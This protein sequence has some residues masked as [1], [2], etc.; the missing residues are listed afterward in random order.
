MP[1]RLVNATTKT[2]PPPRR[3]P[4]VRLKTVHCNQ[5][6][7]ASTSPNATSGWPSKV[8]S[9]R[10]GSCIPT[11]AGPNAK[12]PGRYY[13]KCPVGSPSRQWNGWCDNNIQDVSHSADDRTRHTKYNVDLNNNLRE[14]TSAIRNTV[15]ILVIH[16]LIGIEICVFLV[17]H[18][19]CRY[20]ATLSTNHATIKLISREFFMA[21]DGRKFEKLHLG[22]YQ[23]ETYVDAFDRACKFASGL[24]KLG[25]DVNTRTAILYGCA[26]VFVSFMP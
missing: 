2:T 9:C 12:N 10:A 24:I 5:A 1:Q 23:W 17:I 20:L 11:K 6:D 8:C 18:L 21:S 22:E 15:R 7:M 16:S 25:H 14:L 26:R 19:M 13:Y 3:R 4:L